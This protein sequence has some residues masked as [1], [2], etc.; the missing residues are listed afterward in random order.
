M[1]NLYQAPIDRW[2]ICNWLFVSV[3]FKER[4]EGEPHIEIRFRSLIVMIVVLCRVLNTHL[5][6]GL[7]LKYGI[8]FMYF[9]SLNPLLLH[10]CNEKDCNY[11]LH[12]CSHI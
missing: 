6:I 10:Y 11:L 7:T 8:C 3:T 5:S 2:I 4:T 1:E 12:Y 9:K